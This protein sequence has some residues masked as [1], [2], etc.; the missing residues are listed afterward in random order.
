MVGGNRRPDW[1][2]LTDMHKY[3]RRCALPAL[4]LAALL[5]A[6]ADPDAGGAGSGGQA[7]PTSST[8][9]TTT[10]APT[11]TGVQ[12]PST[13]RSEPSRDAAKMVVRGT[14]REG[15]EPGCKLLEVDQVRRWL[16]VGGGKDADKLV[17]GARVEVVG[18]HSPG[19]LSYCQQAEPL[20]VLSVTRLQ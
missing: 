7:S 19:Q 2:V 9:T 10:S 5:A 3:P 15:V 8:A 18:V 4:V 13:S 20:Q 6:C 1:S 11:T 12:A 16:L 17:P 14:V